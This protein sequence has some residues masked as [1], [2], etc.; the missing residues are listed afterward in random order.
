MKTKYLPYETIRG[1]FPPH[2]PPTHTLV[3]ATAIGEGTR[4]SYYFVPTPLWEEFHALRTR[5]EQEARLIYEIEENISPPTHI[6]TAL[7]YPYD[8]N[9]K[10]D[11]I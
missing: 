2:I 11:N 10:G 9:E 4:E 3:Q 6:A 1:E 8:F 7:P 5:L